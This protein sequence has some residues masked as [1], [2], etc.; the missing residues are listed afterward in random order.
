M[1]ITPN[2]GGRLSCNLTPL[3]VCG[4]G[5]T[6]L[7]TQLDEIILDLNGLNGQQAGPCLLHKTTIAS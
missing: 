5:Q 3:D 1:P 7:W 2:K 6:R 4:H